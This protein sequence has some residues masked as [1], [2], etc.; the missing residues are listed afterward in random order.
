MPVHKFEP[1]L[2]ATSVTNRAGH[3]TRCYGCKQKYNNNVYPT[4]ASPSAENQVPENKP[5]SYQEGKTLG[6]IKSGISQRGAAQ[7]TGCS[8][9]VLSLKCILLHSLSA[10]GWYKLLIIDCFD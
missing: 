10:G 8:C 9:G 7:A 3:Y 1:T 5:T 4:T 2:I 6:K